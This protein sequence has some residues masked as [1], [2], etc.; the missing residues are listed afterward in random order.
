LWTFKRAKFKN[1]G[2]HLTISSGS[3]KTATEFPSGEKFCP[4]LI[5]GTFLTTYDWVAKPI[6][7]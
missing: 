1:A 5:D 2:S 6:N 3:T 7:P 4:Y